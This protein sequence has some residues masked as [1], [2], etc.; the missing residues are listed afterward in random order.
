MQRSLI[1]ASTKSS[2][3]TQESQMRKRQST[4]YHGIITSD[5]LVKGLTHGAIAIGLA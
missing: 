4:L 1:Q 2:K 5:D 3:K